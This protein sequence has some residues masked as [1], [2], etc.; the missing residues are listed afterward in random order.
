LTTVL[1]DLDGVVYRGDTLI[2][3][4]DSALRRLIET[5]IDVWFVTNNST[6]HPKQVVAKLNLLTG[7]DFDPDRV[8]T[9][10][11]AG[12]R[13][14]EPG[15]GPCLVVGEE[16]IRAALE[17]A[18]FEITTD[19]TMARSVMVGLDRDTDYQ[20]IADAAEAVRRGA[21]F[22][23]SNDDPTYPTSDGLLPGAG[24][25]VAAIAIA[26]GRSPEVAGKPN[27]PMRRL[28]RS[29][30][31]GDAWVIGDRVDTDIA[32]AVEEEGWRSILV[33]SG[34]T[35]QG[36]PTADLVAADL[37]EAVGLVLGEP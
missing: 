33:L 17:E 21:R 22:I 25:M 16:G 7:L 6:R 24:S 19:P 20:R 11:Q 36:S 34:V 4:S 29:R 9:S 18:G 26:A 30:G 8:F 5:G 13:L 23:A 35:K 27:L 14:L 3:G 31:V 10:P 32:M 15:D 37:G 1:C 2:D 28:I 12:V